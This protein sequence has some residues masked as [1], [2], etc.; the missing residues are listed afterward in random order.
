MKEYIGEV[1]PSEIDFDSLKDS[2]D[3]VSCLYN[4]I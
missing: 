3:S 1:I 4:V 2:K